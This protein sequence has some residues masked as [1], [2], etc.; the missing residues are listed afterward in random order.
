MAEVGSTESVP[1]PPAGGGRG[2][3]GAARALY[4]RAS[5]PEA[6]LP[7]GRLVDDI[8]AELGRLAAGAGASP[9]DALVAETATWAADER[10]RYRSVLGLAEGDDARGV[11]ARRAALGC[12]PLGLVSGAWLQWL[13]DPANADDPE[14]LRV[15]WVYAADVGAGR[16]RDSRGSAYLALLR[17][18]GR[19]EF[20]VPPSRLA[21]DR[22]V[23]D[24]AFHVPGLLLA[25]SRRP[26]DFRPEVLG[27]DLCLRTVGTLPAL[28]VVRAHDAAAADWSALDADDPRQVDAPSAGSEVRA[29]VEVMAT[30]DRRR[31]ATG[32]AWALAAL[33][34]W[35]DDLRA[36]LDAA[37]HPAHEMAELLRLRAREGAVYHHGVKLHGRY[38]SDWLRD[39]ETDPAPLL[40][41]LATSRLLKPGRS[42]SSVLVNGLIDERGPMFRVFAPEDVTIMRRWIDAIPSAGATAADATA[43]AG[44]RPQVPPLVLP[45]LDDP[46]EEGRTPGDLREAYHLL[47][48]RAGTAA[49][50][51]FAV[52]YVRGW[53]RRSRHGMDDGE[54]RLPA[55]WDAAGLRPW[56]VDQHDRAG[57]E[58]EEG[59]DL[60]LP[61][62]DELI[63]ATVQLAPLTL[64]DGSWL[65]GFTDYEEA[66]SEIGHPLFETYWDELG[67][68]EA[69]LNHPLIYRE[70]LDE[71][72]VHLPPTGSLEFARWEGFRDRSFELPV[73]WLC[74]GRFPRTFLPEVLGLNLAMELS[75]VGGTYRRG[76]MAL[77]AHGFSTRFV[78][79]HNTIDNV[80]SGHSAWAAD[81]VDTYMASIPESQRAGA[82]AEA[83]ERVRAGYRSLNPPSGFWARAAGR[84]ARLKAAGETRLAA[85]DGPAGAARRVT[86]TIRSWPSRGR[87]AVSLVAK[88]QPGG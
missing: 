72:G 58:F 77:Q 35:S 43:A 73:Y 78:D 40:E 15:L 20:A 25:M 64:I 47:H 31:A 55:R 54:M 76:R 83:W 38:L 23:T 84:T 59:L 57:R 49:L 9:I 30:G 75:G 27:A 4:V 81:A 71:M 70:V 87:A 62:R 17:R 5:G 39:C 52:A 26:D 80:A 18:L 2:P 85:V 33:R 16:P 66:A 51:R 37:R 11:L 3:R 1:A 46:V 86:T 22:R 36:D 28:E 42:A 67:N 13:S 14:V 34:R 60:P 6:T 79:I 41:A 65:R 32:F 82:G 88:E 53:L 56:L 21:L 48:R 69:K 19:A 10:E 61:S 44:S 63:D 29:V 7:D 8:R 68:G 50:R 12:A 24:A 74:I 45:S